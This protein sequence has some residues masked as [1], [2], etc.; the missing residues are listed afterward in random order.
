MN[1]KE[2][3][4]EVLKD[5]EILYNSSTIPRLIAE[6]YI[7]RKKGKVNKE[8]LYPKYYDIKTKSK[9]KWC[10]I[11]SRDILLE[12]YN[13]PENTV[14]KCFTYYYSEKGIRVFSSIPEDII[15]AYNGHLFSRYRERMNLN[16]PNVLDIVK[17]FNTQNPETNYAMG[18][19]F[20]GRNKY[21]GIVK[22]GFVLGEYI[23]EDKWYVNKT[24]INRATPDSIVGSTEK[25]IIN[26]LKDFLIT[27]D[28]EKDKDLYDELFKL[29]HSFVPVEN[30]E[31]IKG[32]A[33]KTI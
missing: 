22:E 25:S 24:F 19:E 4:R 17:L 21:F 15:T 9:N 20:E 31:L 12:R 2:I 3:T 14:Y 32:M 13:I 27:M 7:E 5:S 11:L 1:H 18:P 26:S 16:I 29:Y 33:I 30:K 10:F 6:Y 28:K 23:E 8:A